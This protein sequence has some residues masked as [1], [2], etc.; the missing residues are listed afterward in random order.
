MA[1][2]ISPWVA[3]SAEYRPDRYYRY[4]EL[5][6]L[7]HAWARQYPDLAKIESIG[8][9]LEGREIWALTVTNTKTGAADDKPAFFVDANIHAG[10]VTGCATVL[11]LLNHL[12]TGYGSDERVTRLLDEGALYAV[13]CIMLDGA[14]RY[15][16]SPERMRSSV[17]SYPESE[18]QEGLIRQDLNGDGIASAMRI[19][20]PNGPW[21][22][23]PDDARVMIRREP[24][25]VGGDYYFVLP[26]GT[27]KDWDGGSIKLA[28]D[29]MG[30]DLNRNFPHEWAPEWKQRG[31]GEFPLSEPETRALAAF[32]HA[33]PNI[34]ASQH[35]HTWSAVILR[36]SSNLP[37]DDLPKF[38]LTVFKAIGKM[39]EEETGYPCISIFH[40]Y[41]YDK[42]Q[43]IHGT[44]LDW[45]YSTFGA[46]AYS[47]EFWSLPMKAGIE[48]KDH[49][50]WMKDHPAADDVAMAR[51]LDNYVDGAGI[52][53]WTPFE[54]P[55]LGAVEIG[56]WDYKF[57]WQ[58]PPGPLLEEVTA[59]NATFVVRA[60]GTGPRIVIDSTAV[61]PLGGDLYRVSAIVQ[62]TGFLPTYVSEAGKATGRI[63]PVLATLEGGDG[64]KL[65]S[66]K[67]EQDLGHLNGRANQYGSMGSV[68]QYDNLSRARVEWIVSG[69]AGATC[70]LTVRTSKA[71]TARATIALA[72][73]DKD[74]T[75]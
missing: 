19:K 61:E 24:D 10:E 58:N 28:P 74:G 72:G 66:G 39:G 53:E 59:G 46:F 9:T 13:P 42:K 5:T 25:E 22:V 26:E 55:Q 27:I 56:G 51:A 36:P 3:T 60:M 23:S 35:F 34:Y 2:A 63:K 12:L 17:R 69:P 47:T 38:D 49:I 11:W 65:V 20:D 44:V 71:G 6:D 31:S 14:E 54:H 33:H 40:D 70:E 50:A 45:V 41:A 18:Q 32:L 7:L 30:L 75:A 64:V 67:P 37:D 57:A 52:L 15:L 4:H 68:P 1:Q 8:Q 62:N 43:P 16:T 21:K 29:L 48:I 73:A